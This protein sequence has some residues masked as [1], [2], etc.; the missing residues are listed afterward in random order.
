MGAGLS[1]T[2]GDF[3]A[4]DLASVAGLVLDTNL[5]WNG[6]NAL[7]SGDVLSPSSDPNPIIGDPGLPVPDRLRATPVWTGS[8]F[9]GGDDTVGAALARIVAEFG[10]PTSDVVGNADPRWSTA[11]DILGTARGPDPALGAVETGASGGLDTAACPDDLI[12][13]A[14]FGDLVGFSKETADAVDC[15]VYH[16]VTEGVAPGLFAPSE[17]VSRWQ[18]ALFLVRSLDAAGVDL[19]DGADQG[20]VDVAGLSPEALLAVNRLAQLGV[21]NGVGPGVFDPSG[22]VSRWQMALFLVRWLDVAG[23]AA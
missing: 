20:F 19:P 17:T 8:Q 1:E 3:S 14:P 13:D 22:V 18:M 12:P 21:T 9:R 5:Y 11:A 2:D 15:L 23:V 6:G 7:P 16:D 10:T 4:G